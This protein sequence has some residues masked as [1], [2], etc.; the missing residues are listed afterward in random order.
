MAVPRRHLKND[1][2]WRIVDVVSGTHVWMPD[3]DLR[4]LDPK[5]LDGLIEDLRKGEAMTRKLRERLEA[6]RNTSARECPS[7]GR[8]VVGRSDAIYCTGSCRVKAHRES[9]RND[10][11][12]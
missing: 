6:L 5:M 3:K 11:S 10:S 7:C 1:P 4:A 9:R 2:D 8:P 12:R